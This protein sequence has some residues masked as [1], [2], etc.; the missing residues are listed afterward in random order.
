MQLPPPPFA[1]RL[2]T[3][4]QLQ[5]GWSADGKDPRASDVGTMKQA[6]L[7]YGR[8]GFP[9]HPLK[10]KDKCPRTKNGFKDATTEVEII[11]RYWTNCPDANIGIR[12][13]PQSFVA[14]DVDPENGGSHS[15]TQLEKRYGTL[16]KT[17]E[18]STGGGGRHIMFEHP[19]SKVTSRVGFAPGLDMRGDE[20]YIV[21]PP[22]IHE[23]GGRYE[24]VHSPIENSLAPMPSWLLE[25]VNNNHQL[26][27]SVEGAIPEGLRNTTLTSL[28]GSMRRRGMTEEG[29]KAALLEENSHRCYPPL[30]KREVERIAKNVARYE[31]VS[32]G[33]RFTSEHPYH[34]VPSGLYYTKST[35]DGPVS[36]FLTNFTAR[37][38][39]DVTEDDGVETRHSYEIEAELKGRSSRF[40]VPSTQF[41]G[42]RW[43]AENLGAQAIVYPYVGRERTPVAIQFLSEDMQQ[44]TVFTH[45]GWREVNNQWVYLHASGGLGQEGPVS[46]IEV[47]LEGGLSRYRLT[48]PEGDLV[49][50]IKASLRFLELADARITIPLFCSIWRA[51]A[52]EVDCS[53]H[54]SG[55]TGEFKTEVAALCQ[56]HFGSEMSR[57]NLPANWSSTDNALED[58]TFKAKNALLVID[59]FAPVG[60]P[61]DVQRLHKKADRIFRAQGNSSGRQRMRA[62][63]SLRPERPPRG[64]ILST[65][66]D[67][68]KGHSLKARLWVCDLSPG[69]VSEQI[70]SLCQ[71]DAARGK[72]V[73]ATAGFIQWLA[74]QYETIRRNLQKELRELRKTASKDELHRRTPDIVANLAI[75]WRLFLDYAKDVG[76][77]T[78]E[79]RQELWDRGWNALGE[80]A[81]AQQEQQATDEPTQQFLAML[82]AAITS[83][84]AHVASPDGCE[85]DNPK[86]WGW[87]EG[88]DYPT[89]Q[90]SRIGWVDGDDLYLEPTAAYAA[91]QTMARAS[92]GSLATS[93]ATLR[94][95]LKERNLLRSTKENRL[96]VRKMLGGVRHN[97]LHLHRDAL[98]QLVVQSVVQK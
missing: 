5:A 74:P 55:Q 95:R 78:A 16:P 42:L 75:G 85:P 15:L 91:A 65:G 39:A 81:A 37:I 64:L 92:G 90:G 77:I 30:D 88:Y 63:G 44:K 13:G 32:D 21:A 47:K 45:T 58:S 8:R 17:W 14:L 41:G 9:V 34:A 56:Q 51:I 61:Y 23:S 6:A 38:A 24:W 19:G 26:S 84:K 73:K 62:D 69:D 86:A 97:V 7:D 1:K 43:V 60:T 29:I 79:Q 71:R 12:T 27:P 20:A 70:L 76:A 68:P 94:K 31:P 36:V 33:G 82:K 49:D 72:Y 28:A 3:D 2:E 35:K 10:P 93:D 98:V 87:R 53:I 59:D 48:E 40:T 96:T 66:E 11:N 25:L 52:G 4:K 89:S 50:S 80:G 18:Q 83:G 67:T 22:S 54:L 57:L 46:G